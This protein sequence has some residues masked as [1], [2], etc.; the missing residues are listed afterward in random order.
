ML[1]SNAGIHSRGLV[2]DSSLDDFRQ[3]METNFFGA[4]CCIKAV[5]P[6]MQARRAGTIVNSRRYPDASRLH[7]K[8]LTPR[9]NGP[10]KQ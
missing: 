9:R 1:V 5:L 3:V 4:L 7:R 6:S 2:S 10:S 8:P